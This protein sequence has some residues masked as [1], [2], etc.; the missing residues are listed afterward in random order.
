M[1]YFSERKNVDLYSSMMEG[2]DSSFI[3]G[4]VAKR[5]PKGATLLELGMGTGA[6][7]IALS[8]KYEVIGSDTSPLFVSDFKLKSD[9]EVQTLDAVTVEIDKKFDCIFSNKVLQHLSKDAFVTSLKNQSKHLNE[10][11]MLFFTLWHGTPREEFELEGA[12][13]F[14]YYDKATLESLVPKELDVENITYYAEFE[15]ND[16]MIVI[17]RI[18]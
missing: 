12:L 16:S 3:V 1:D 18:K 15:K 11:G 10:N 17:L 14:V 2:Y 5:L 8:E 9:I 13:R 7:L 6:D 4:E